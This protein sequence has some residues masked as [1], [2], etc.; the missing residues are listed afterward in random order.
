MN[1][2]GNVTPRPLEVGLLTPTDAPSPID[3]EMNG[4]LQG[5]GATTPVQPTTPLQEKMD[6]EAL[7]D[8]L[9]QAYKPDNYNY[10]RLSSGFQELRKLQGLT[11][12]KEFGGQ[13]PVIERMYL[14]AIRFIGFFLVSYTVIKSCEVYLF[15]LIG[16]TS[17][18]DAVVVEFAYP[19]LD[20]L[21]IPASKIMF[22]GSFGFI[23]SFVVDPL[24]LI[25]G[26]II[27]WFLMKILELRLLVELKKNNHFGLLL[28]AKLKKLR[29]VPG[30]SIASEVEQILG[31]KVGMR[32]T[33]IYNSLSIDKYFERYN[34][35]LIEVKAVTA[36]GRDVTEDLREK[37]SNLKSSVNKKQFA[38]VHNHAR[39]RS[40]YALV[41]FFNYK[42]TFDFF[43]EAQHYPK[44]E[45]QEKAFM[46]FKRY[47]YQENVFFGPDA[48]DIDW[49]YFARK[50]PFDLKLIKIGMQV[51]FFGVLPGVTYYIHY[52]FC[53]EI[54]RAILGSGA[55]ILTDYIVLF[56]ILRLVISALYGA[57]LSFAIDS[58]FDYSQ[59]KTYSQRIEAKFYFH[60]FF[61]MLNF[62]AADFY[63]LMSA[64]ISTISNETTTSLLKNHQGFIF[65]AGLKVAAN[66]IISPFIQIFVSFLPRIEARIKLM[67]FKNTCI[68]LDA[69]KRDL[70]TQHDVGVMASFLVQCIFFVSF[71]SG[72]LMPIVNWV[73]ILGLCGFYYTEK[74]LIKNVYSMRKGMNI[75]L[76]NMVYKMFFW[77]YV[78]G[79]TLSISNAAVIIAYFTSLNLVMLKNF[80]L[81]ALQYGFNIL[82]IGFTMYM[83]MHYSD[84]EIKFRLL[85]SLAA[86]EARNGGV[87]IVGVRT[88]AEDEKRKDMREMEEIGERTPSKH[89]QS[90]GGG[91][92]GEISDHKEERI[93]PPVLNPI[94]RQ[95]TAS[96]QQS[97]ENKFRLRNPRFKSKQGL[98][99][100]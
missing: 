58:Y 78:I 97:F 79:T 69:V 88:N 59:F 34:T 64:G 68:M 3:T 28:T 75:N 95:N 6:R 8:E 93:D 98:Y 40:G 62:I 30:K 77:A 20:Y 72:F 49:N 83:N 42:D 25:V 14:E 73:V 89:K 35:T 41:S 39:L 23:N 4:R 32:V 81:S 13:I 85:Q 74:Y 90:S 21:L 87:G 26:C 27:Y 52:S 84:F 54:L 60:N 56:T 96:K 94:R 16:T 17:E 2:S 80:L 11:T 12:A 91:G 37:L 1:V 43:K 65:A 61:F 33:L 45:Q 10:D 71:F 82:A 51:L 9:S 22:S 24:I 46:V 86:L 15:A 55:N 67:V 66:L 31:R 53:Y 63:A 38:L 100:V 5:D 47:T 48:Y 7:A 18:E 50:T 76:I 92:L 99:T 70:P 36:A 19:A 57:L 44:P 29:K